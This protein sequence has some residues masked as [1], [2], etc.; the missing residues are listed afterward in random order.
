MR[1]SGAQLGGLLLTHRAY[2][3]ALTP[4]RH[5]KSIRYIH[6]VRIGE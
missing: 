5:M 4:L 2:L 1:V 6:L 3:S